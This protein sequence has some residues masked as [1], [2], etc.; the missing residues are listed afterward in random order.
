[1]EIRARYVLVGL[2]T[3]AVTVGV[4]AF[5]Y[6]LQTTGSLGKRTNYEVRFSHSVSG[7]LTGSP[8]LFD[9]IRVG[10]VSAL[11]LV[12]GEPRLID[13]TISVDAHTPVR[14]DTQVSLEFQ[15]LTGF[16][17]VTLEG[18]AP[19]APPLSAPPGK[20]PRLVANEAAGQTMSE[21][22]RQVL[23][24]LDKILGE[25]SEDL[26]SM[27]KNLTA[28]SAAL[29]R[30]SGPVASIVA[31]LE[32]MTGGGKGSGTFYTLSAIPA[33]AA[34]AGPL[35]KQLAVADPSALMAYDS[36]KVLVQNEAGQLQGFGNAKWA[37]TVPKLMQAKIV[38]SFENNASPGEV[39]RP[40]EGVTPDFQ[41]LTEIRRFQ[42]VEAPQPVAEAEVSARLVTGD[43]QIAGARLFSAKEPVQSKEEAEAARALN[44]AFER[45]EA[46]LLQWTRTA[47]ANAG[48]KEQ[49]AA[50]D[51]EHA[52]KKP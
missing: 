24:R 5:V 41:L 27:V 13:A 22:A 36:E 8:V 2:F 19:D 52:R 35:G 15:G 37:D 12:P 33:P 49:P 10:E 44:A 42:I 21:A 3:L 29:G 51:A 46:D 11:K 26:H 31:G 48:E 18:G 6:W 7:L 23:G 32:R 25:N 28:S 9:G 34:P 1:M 39:N 47:I 40:I 4:F 50:A 38:Q 14:S 30:N 17:V 20:L 16:A 43:G 45:I